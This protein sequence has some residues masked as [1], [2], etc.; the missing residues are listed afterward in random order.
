V[1]V[2]VLEVL[3]GVVVVLGVALLLA[4]VGG[5]LPAAEPDAADPALP[6]DR[7]LTSDDIPRLRFRLALR[8]YRMEDVDS[9]L[10]AVHRSLAEAEQRAAAAEPQT[11]EPA[12]SEPGAAST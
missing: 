10:D 12:P 2:F 5:G 1:A 9:A 4:S 11:D 7:V 8:G 3:L 6:T